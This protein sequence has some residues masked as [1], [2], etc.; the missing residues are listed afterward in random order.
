MS[1]LKMNYGQYFFRFS[2]LAIFFGGGLILVILV[3]GTDNLIQWMG[4][5]I[6][7]PLGLLLFAWF[8]TLYPKARKEF[9]MLDND[10]I[11]LN[12]K[13]I[14]LGEIKKVHEVTHVLKPLQA[15][16]PGITIETHQ[17]EQLDYI[18]YYAVK[19]KDI[20]QFTRKLKK[21]I[22]KRDGFTEIIN[23]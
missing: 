8:C 16:C 3:P 21:A 18:S 1:E 13:T 11:V 6:G 2:Q 22:K 20:K 4:K 23:K 19:E 17:G 10:K 9:I 15:W 12:G 7:L 5:F 14:L